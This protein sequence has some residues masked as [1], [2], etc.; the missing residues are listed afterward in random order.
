MALFSRPSPTEARTRCVQVY[1]FCSVQAL[2]A[3]N[4]IVKAKQDR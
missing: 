2:P 1:T 4:M 3:I